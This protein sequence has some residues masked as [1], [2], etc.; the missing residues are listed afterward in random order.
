MGQPPDAGA[1]V[2]LREISKDMVRD[3]TA[4]AVRP[5][6]RHYVASNAA[7]IAEAQSHQQAWIRAIY[8]GE[9]PVG[10]V[11]LHGEGHV[12]SVA[13]SK[14]PAKKPLARSDRKEVWLGHKVPWGCGGIR[15]SPE[16][17]LSSDWGA[18]LPR[19]GDRLMFA[20][21]RKIESVARRRSRVSGDGLRPSQRR[22]VQRRGVVGDR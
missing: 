11:M 22:R 12:S 1:T 4:L 16:S 6:Q 2:T 15:R 18:S 9:T 7:S 14:S 17:G 8:A 13:E 21:A 19:F 10:L 5:E 3:I 20:P